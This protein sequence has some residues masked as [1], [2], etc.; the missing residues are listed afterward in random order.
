VKYLL[1]FISSFLIQ[2]N[3]YA[4][5]IPCTSD[6]TEKAT[7]DKYQLSWMCHGDVQTFLGKQKA[8][9]HVIFCQ[10]NKFE[11]LTSELIENI[12]RSAPLWQMP[13]NRL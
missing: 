12:E 1:S 2:L 13:R 10:V 8:S 7:D 4:Q 9:T 6:L 11:I 3:C 5:P